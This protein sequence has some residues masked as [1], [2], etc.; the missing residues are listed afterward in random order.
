M[1]SDFNKYWLM[2]L[3]LDYLYTGVT[4]AFLYH[5]TRRTG[6]SGLGARTSHGNRAVAPRTAVTATRVPNGV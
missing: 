3:F 5:N 6:S 2:V 4:E 1:G